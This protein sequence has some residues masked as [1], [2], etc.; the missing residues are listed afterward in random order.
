MKV[1]DREDGDH[2]VKG[3]ER[4]RVKRH[5]VDAR[6]LP[7]LVGRDSPDVCMSPGAFYT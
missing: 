4:A 7:R 6:R 5:Y 2:L 1:N 3:H